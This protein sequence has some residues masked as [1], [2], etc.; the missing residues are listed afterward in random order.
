MGTGLTRPVVT[1]LISV[2][3]LIS[4]GREDITESRETRNKLYEGEKD[5]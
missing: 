4:L 3:S 2:I 1:W 5:I